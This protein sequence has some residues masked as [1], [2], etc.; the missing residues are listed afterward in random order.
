MN[1]ELITLFI[2]AVL[3]AGVGVF[4]NLINERFIRRR[5]AEK[6]KIEDVLAA[7]EAKAEE[8]KAKVVETLTE[9]IAPGTPAPEI[10]HALASQFRVGGDLIVNQVV[11]EGS[12]FIE[13]LVSGYHHQALSQAKVQFWFSI[14]AA[15]VGFCYIL[16]SAATTGLDQWASVMKIMPG[17]V[18]DAVAAL[19]FRQAEQTRQRATEL[20][21]RLRKDSQM[22]MAQKLLTSIEDTRIRSAAQAQI[23]LHMAGLEPKE[24]DIGALIGPAESAK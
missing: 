19:F 1:T 9:R 17:V 8:A 22:S 6:Q 14:I 5:Q 15:T 18:I 16:F 4:L 10:S 11:K 2:S 12:G 20:Y 3:T 7:V 13:E 24:I 21:D 23:A